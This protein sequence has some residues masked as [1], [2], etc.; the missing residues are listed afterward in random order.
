MTFFGRWTYA[1]LWKEGSVKDFCRQFVFG[2]R[3]AA[4]RFEAPCTTIARPTSE[5]SL[6]RLIVSAETRGRIIHV[7]YCHVSPNAL[8]KSGRGYTSDLCE[9]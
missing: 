2:Y 9:M 6:V 8:C 3:R 5:K 1:Q 7:T 4:A